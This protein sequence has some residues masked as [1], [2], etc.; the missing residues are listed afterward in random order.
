MYNDSKRLNFKL[1]FNL[2]SYF[3]LFSVA[4][5]KKKKDRIGLYNNSSYY[6][7]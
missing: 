4:K 6:S 5:L 7:F 3:N 2:Q 1:S